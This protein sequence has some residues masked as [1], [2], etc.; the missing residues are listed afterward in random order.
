MN[1][2]WLQLAIGTFALVLCGC[3]TQT[4]KEG[5]DLSTSGIAY[6]DAVDSLLDVTTDTVVD[7]DNNELIKTRISSSPEKGLADK[8]AAMFDLLSEI[9]AFRARTRL[10]KAYFLNLQALAD[11]PVKDDVGSAVKSLS[12][13]ISKVNA[14]LGGKESLSDEQKSQIGTLAGLVASS[15]QAEKIKRALSR[16]AEIIGTN[17]ALQQRQ[18]ANI[19]AILKDRYEADNRLFHAE[20]VVQPYVD[21]QH[22][23]DA[24]SWTDA[25]KR[26]L[27]SAFANQQLETAN[28]A[29]TQL[30][31]VW[32][33]ILQ[34]KTDLGALDGLISDVNEFTSS[35]EAVKDSAK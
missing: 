6:A 27:K 19:T 12:D 21:I 25:R 16:D 35:M 33:E 20:H 8:D 17:L 10:L 4:I 23:L 32:T 30:Q 15:I 24:S 31:S 26:W 3:V 22:P 18:L 13:S 1:A 5:K 34:G 7:F 11:S 9:A 29:A 2:K 14:S 28:T